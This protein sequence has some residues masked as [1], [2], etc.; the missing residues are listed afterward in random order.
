[1]KT[2]A[3]AIPTTHRNDNRSNTTNMAMLIYRLPFAV[4]GVLCLGNLYFGAV[5]CTPFQTKK[6]RA[7]RPT[8]MTEKGKKENLFGGHTHYQVA[9]RHQKWGLKFG[10]NLT[11]LHELGQSPHTR[12]TP[13]C[14]VSFRE[15]G[16][17]FI[18][19]RALVRVARLW[20]C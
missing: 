2:A 10:A 14:L 18:L 16:C 20:W 11:G 17:C 8:K 6:A 4:A 13:Q 19:A 15:R 12:R 3:I 9:R 1:M 7:A 5:D